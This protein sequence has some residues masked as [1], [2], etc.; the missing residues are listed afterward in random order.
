MNT[1]YF[2]GRLLSL[3]IPAFI[4]IDISAGTIDFNSYT[5]IDSNGRY[6]YS[7]N[8]LGCNYTSQAQRNLCKNG[9]EW[10]M[11]TTVNSYCLSNG[12]LRISGTTILTNNNLLSGFTGGTFVIAKDKMG[13]TICVISAKTNLILNE[14]SASDEDAEAFGWGVSP[15][16]L[17]FYKWKPYVKPNIRT[18][19]WEADIPS[20][21]ME[22]SPEITIEQCHTPS[23]RALKELKE[24]LK[25][26]LNFSISNGYDIA[27]LI[28]AAQNNTL[29]FPMVTDFIDNV[30]LWSQGQNFIT[31]SQATAAINIIDAVKTLES[32]GM[33]SV[34][35][36]NYANFVFLA[37]GFQTAI[38]DK[39]A[40]SGIT[41]AKGI[42]EQIQYLLY[43]KQNAMPPDISSL[44]T[45][46]SNL[47]I[48]VDANLDDAQRA[49]FNRAIDVV[50]AIN[51]LPSKLAWEH[52]D[53]V[54]DAINIALS[55]DNQNDALTTFIVHSSL[56][57]L[58]ANLGVAISSEYGTNSLQIEYYYAYMEIYKNISS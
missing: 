26:A 22:M 1:K 23:N 21:V 24:I 12:N 53:L 31:S 18:C 46:V 27:I 20:Y 41:N 55:L 17:S 4:V 10:G 9:Q 19:S 3:L 45:I 2:F 56:N 36:D 16:Y 47:K 35:P 14:A 40:A 15:G 5:S 30:I 50:N 49:N 57:L 11:S 7:Q 8:P 34:K 28:S 43:S 42:L 48:L 39:T 13:F 51:K 32:Q 38:S 58:L 44:V 37:S 6:I 29:T 54:F 52:D 25:Y 33:I